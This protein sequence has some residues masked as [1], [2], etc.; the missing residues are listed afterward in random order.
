MATFADRIT[1]APLGSAAAPVQR[2]RAAVLR[3]VPALPQIEVLQGWHRNARFAPHWHASWSL[4][5]ID[6]GSCR[7]SCAGSR[8]TASPTDIV[9]IPPFAVHTAGVN[10]D[11]LSMRMLYL[12]ASLVEEVLGV[13]VGSARPV[14]R[15]V[16]SDAHRYAAISM[17]LA[18]SLA[19]LRASLASGLESFFGA[20]PATRLASPEE[21]DPRIARVCQRLRETFDTRPDFDQLADELAISRS[22]LAREFRRVVGLTP[23]EYSR[24]WRLERA[25]QLLA[26]GVALVDTAGIC[27]FADQAHFTRWFKRVFGV[28]PGHYLSRRM[29]RPHAPPR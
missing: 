18:D 24:L 15:H 21:N 14:T 11:G 29:V 5:L 22:H 7:F 23:G 1:Q 8:W 2:P 3:I 16:V 12:P 10:T 20:G 17:G 25:K 26:D 28:T 4:G 19:T 13:P 6:E 9:L 27:G